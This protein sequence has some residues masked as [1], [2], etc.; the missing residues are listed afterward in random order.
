MA[1]DREQS[2]IE[3]SYDRVAKFYADQFSG[4]LARKP[5]DRDLLNR[6]AAEITGRGTACDLGCGPGHIARFLHELGVDVCGIDL[7]AEMV[8]CARRL[9]PQIRFDKGDMLALPV[10]D[11]AF[12]AIA[13]FYSIIHIDRAKTPAALAEIRRALAPDGKLLLSFHGGNDS[14]RL[15]EWYGEEVAVEAHFFEPDEMRAYA[16]QSGLRVTEV[17]ERPPY[18]FEFQ[19]RRI[20]LFAEKS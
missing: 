10:A 7:S 13:A 17:L 2:P 5:F 20:Y 12:S 1:A 4:E 15:D 16:E 14:V 11:G 9:N 3:W 19:S 6:F 18:E 8:H